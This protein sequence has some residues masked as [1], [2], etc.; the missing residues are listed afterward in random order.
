MRRILGIVLPLILL[1]PLR[2]QGQEWTAEQQDLWA[3]EVACWE[4]RDLE[5]TMACFHDDFIGWG[6][7]TAEPTTKAD[8]RPLFAESFD[9]NEQVSLDLQPLAINIQGNTAVL[10]YEATTVTRNKATGEETRSVE[11]WTDV[12]MREGGR[13]SWIADH[14]TV[15]EEG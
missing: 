6:A 11:R 10:I 4:S 8:R 9:T 1:F 3:W 13:W 15:V 7:G 12:A 14:G 2:V 5:T